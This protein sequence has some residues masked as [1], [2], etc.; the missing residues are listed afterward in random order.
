MGFTELD[1][2]FIVCAFVTA[3]VVGG[4]L[5]RI[6]PDS[7][8]ITKERV[9]GGGRGPTISRE[10]SRPSVGSSAQTSGRTTPLT[11]KPPKMMSEAAIKVTASLLSKND[12]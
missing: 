1:S 8:T 12:R 6:H 5:V 4:E 10:L 7:L 3:D 11:A 2:H 9:K